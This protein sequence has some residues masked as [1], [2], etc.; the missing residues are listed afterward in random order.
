ML[1]VLQVRYF[2]NR[3]N[4]NKDTADPQAALDESGQGE[5]ASDEYGE[6]KPIKKESKLLLQGQV[7]HPDIELVFRD[8]QPDIQAVYEDELIPQYDFGKRQV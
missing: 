6:P 8:A 3:K 2:N 5:T 4:E 7:L 1:R